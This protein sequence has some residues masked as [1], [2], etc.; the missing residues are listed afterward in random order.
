VDNPLQTVGISSTS[1]YNVVYTNGSDSCAASITVN[2]PPCPCPVATIS[3]GGNYCAGD[4]IPTVDFDVTGNFPVTIV[5]A[6]NGIPQSP[7][8]LYSDTSLIDPA[9]GIYTILAVTDT[10]L[11]TGTFSGSAV[12]EAFPSPIIADLSGGGQYCDGELIDDITI[13]VIGT[14]LVSIFYSIDG[15]P[16]PVLSDPSS[17]NLGNVPGEYILIILSD[18]GCATQIQDTIIIGVNPVPVAVPSIVDNEI[19]AGENLEFSSSGVFDSYEWS[20]PGGFTSNDQNPTIENALVNG[21]GTYSLSVTENGCESDPVNVPV[22]VNP[23]PQLNVSNDTIICLGQSVSLF[24]SGANELTWSPNITN[25]E[26]FIPGASQ[27]YQV[28]GT[29]QGCSSSTEIIVTVLPMPIPGFTAS[30]YFGYAPLSV[31]FIN[32]SASANSFVWDFGNGITNSLN[33]FSSQISNYEQPGF[34][35]ISLTASNGICDST[36]L[37]S[38]EVIPY[39]EMTIEVPNVFSPNG[40]DIN[41]EY[42]VYVENG[43]LFKAEI[44]NRWGLLM[45]TID[46][47]NKGWDGLV[48]GNPA[49]EGTYFVKYYAKGLDGTEKNGETFFQLV[50]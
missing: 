28:T 2:I 41:E 21:S 25:G 33:D 45:Y 6:F 43:V 15:L 10:T 8:V 3:G 23:V 40:D 16:Q 20:G 42:I 46:E 12:V 1:T 44:L 14:G 7:L 27:T 19:C 5:Y 32:N 35:Y 39:P 26:S 37:D 49:T 29:S 22:I 13:S 17:F 36:I 4:T 34:F 38:I 50:R 9:D 48:N 18:D 30:T 47:L 11:C 31:D 24:A